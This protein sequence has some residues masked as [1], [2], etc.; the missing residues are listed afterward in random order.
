MTDLKRM[1]LLCGLRQI[2][3]WASTGISLH[4]IACAE[5]GQTE[6]TDGERKL[7]LSFLRERWTSL[8]ETERATTSATSTPSTEPEASALTKVE[9]KRRLKQTAPFEAVL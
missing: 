6:L 2:D 5:R 8:E 1:R 7:L 3:L 4:R 9:R